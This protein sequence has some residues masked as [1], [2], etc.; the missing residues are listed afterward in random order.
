MLREPAKKAPATAVTISALGEAAAGREAIVSMFVEASRDA[1]LCTATYLPPAMTPD[2]AR[3]FCRRSEGFVIHEDGA[4]A[5]VLLIHQVPRPGEGV[6]LPAGSIEIERWIL[7]RFRD[8]GLL[9]RAWP[10]L[11]TSLSLHHRHLIAVCWEDNR[12]ACRSLRA[13]GF[14]SL[15][16][17][18]WSAP[19]ESGW[20][21]V[22]VYDLRHAPTML[23]VSDASV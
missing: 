12:A 7:P 3:A 14:Q 4:P 20:C 6:Q 17:S 21:E 18:F 5:G 22:F 16:R 1:A 8:R 11:I 23:T 15:G 10:A 2:Q 9:R 19:G 13:C